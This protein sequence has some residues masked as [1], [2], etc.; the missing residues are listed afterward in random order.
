MTRC[1]KCHDGSSTAS[2]DICGG[3]GQVTESVARM[4]VGSTVTVRLPMEEIGVLRARTIPSEPPTKPR[5]REDDPESVVERADLVRQAR[6][7]AFALL[8]SAVLS[9]LVW[10][11]VR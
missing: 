4:W 8:A 6:L 9:L 3:T 2:C 5:A 10:L 1:P 7:W 11:L